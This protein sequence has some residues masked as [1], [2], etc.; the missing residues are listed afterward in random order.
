MRGVP[1]GAEPVPEVHRA[2]GRQGEA[3][4]GYR[5]RSLPVRRTVGDAAAAVMASPSPPDAP[6]ATR[7]VNTQRRTGTTPEALQ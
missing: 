1:E 2:T 3:E 5:T 7:C 6:A 4:S